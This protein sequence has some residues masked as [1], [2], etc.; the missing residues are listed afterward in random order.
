MRSRIVFNFTFDFTAWQM[1]Q[2]LAG[3]GGW[4]IVSVG[5]KQ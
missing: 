2:G 5:V 1:S 3:G 4:H